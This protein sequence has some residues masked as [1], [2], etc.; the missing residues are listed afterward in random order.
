MEKH[1]IDIACLQETKIP[2]NRK[3]KIKDYIFITSTDIKGGAKKKD[4]NSANAKAKS[5]AQA[6][7]GEGGQKQKEDQN[8]NHFQN[9][10]QEKEEAKAVY[11]TTQK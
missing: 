4:D 8:L 2:T 1:E 5:K 3:F 7:G 9:Q 10:K 11:T 6:K